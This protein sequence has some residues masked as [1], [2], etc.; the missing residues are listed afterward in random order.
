MLVLFQQRQRQRR[1]SQGQQQSIYS[2]PE[3]PMIFWTELHLWVAKSPR[4][5]SFNEL[6][7]KMM[8]YW[9]GSFDVVPSLRSRENGVDISF[10]CSSCSSSRSGT[11]HSSLPSVQRG[12]YYLVLSRESREEFW[13]ITTRKGWNWTTACICVWAIVSTTTT[14]DHAF[15]GHA[16]IHQI[17]VG[18]HC[19]PPSSLGNLSCNDRTLV[20]YCIRIYLVGVTSCGVHSNKNEVNVCYA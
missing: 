5:S 20:L 3:E 6:M 14:T 1:I 18:C 15:L 7:L 8:L 19:S 10:H 9:H 16:W 11:V 13:K 4:Q 2:L 17:T 12:G